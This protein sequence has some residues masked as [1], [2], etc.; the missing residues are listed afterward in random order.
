MPPL[1]RPHELS[2]I[3][4]GKWWRT[5]CLLARPAHGAVIIWIG[6]R[7]VSILLFA[8]RSRLLWILYSMQNKSQKCPTSPFTR[9]A[10]RGEFRARAPLS[11][12]CGGLPRS[13]SLEAYHMSISAKPRAATEPADGTICCARSGLNFVRSHRRTPGAHRRLSTSDAS[14]APALHARQPAV[15]VS[16]Q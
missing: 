13:A 10:T 6:A 1:L 4:A 12:L 16:R 3:L 9:V 11:H 8:K 2:Q 5:P 14:R 7:A 15:A